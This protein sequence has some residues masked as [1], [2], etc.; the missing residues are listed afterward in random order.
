MANPAFESNDG[1]LRL[2]FDRRLM[3]PLRGPVVTSD[4]GPLAYRERDDAIG[5]SAMAV[6][7]FLLSNFLGW[8]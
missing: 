5:L 4:A 1:D 6:C 8:S 2:N 3:L 7:T